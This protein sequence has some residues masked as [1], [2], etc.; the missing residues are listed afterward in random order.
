MTEC[1]SCNDLFCLPEGLIRKLFVF[2]LLKRL[3]PN[4][5]TSS[6]W[7][8]TLRHL[9]KLSFWAPSKRT[10]ALLL[11]QI[12]HEE[13]PQE[14]HFVK[15]KI[16]CHNLSVETGRHGKIALDERIYSLCS[17]NKIE[18]EAHLLRLARLKKILLD[19]RHNPF[20]N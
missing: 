6:Y 11:P 7:N 18:D 19:K 8:Q 16:G 13:I 12:Q 9:R 4:K 3:T 17:D 20:Q 14:E 2:T 10:R 1:I 5:A 15:L